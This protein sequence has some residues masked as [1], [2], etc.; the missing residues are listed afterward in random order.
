MVHFQT[1]SG[2]TVT[3]EYMLTHGRDLRN[4]CVGETADSFPVAPL[5]SNPDWY[6]LTAARTAS[7]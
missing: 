6:R 2:D 4:W 1:P 7:A 3:F 5:D